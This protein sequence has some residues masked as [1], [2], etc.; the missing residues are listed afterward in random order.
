MAN[1]TESH[2]RY[3]TTKKEYSSN[4]LDIINASEQKATEPIETYLV[5]TFKHVLDKDGPVRRYTFGR[6]D[7]T[8]R[9]RTILMVGET[10]TGKSTL[11]NRML[12]YMLAEGRISKL[13]QDLKDTEAEKTKLMEQSYQ[14]ILKLREFALKLDSDSTHRNI[15]K[16][17]EML[18]NNEETEKV[19]ELQKMIEKS[20]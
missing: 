3:S 8:K 5:S 4:W 10:G 9:N 16:L 20:V 14:C 1:S 17:I 15:L 18:K 6:K 7:P 13:E 19:A 11:I 12:N 2:A